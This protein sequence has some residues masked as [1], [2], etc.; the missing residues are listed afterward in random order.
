M[1]TFGYLQ[2]RNAVPPEHSTAPITDIILVNAK[3]ADRVI[4]ASA[5]RIVKDVPVSVQAHQPINPKAL[6]I[7]PP[8]PKV[9]IAHPPIKSGFAARVNGRPPVQPHNP[10]ASMGRLDSTIPAMETRLNARRVN[11][12][13]RVSPLRRTAR[14]AL[15]PTRVAQA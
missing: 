8:A 3:I 13:F 14:S 5:E 1:I 6:R 2:T 12:A 7:A 11:T 4:T 9:A 15:I 10:T